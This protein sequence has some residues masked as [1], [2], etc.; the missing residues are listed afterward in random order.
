L[1]LFFINRAFDWIELAAVIFIFF[2]LLDGG[3]FEGAAG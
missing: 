1:I 3:G 2:L